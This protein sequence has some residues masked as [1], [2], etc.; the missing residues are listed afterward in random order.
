MIS[1][2]ICEICTHIDRNQRSLKANKFMNSDLLRQEISKLIVQYAN[3]NLAPKA[4]VPDESVIPPS[5]K[6]IGARELQLMV[7]AS[8]DGWLTAGRFNAKF[9]RSEKLRVGKES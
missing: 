8:L 3:E 9:A 6:V 7:D 5:G 4:F 1:K 2:P